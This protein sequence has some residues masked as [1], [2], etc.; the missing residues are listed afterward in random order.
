MT[1]LLRRPTESDWE[2]WRD[3]RLRMLA[4]TPHAFAESLATARDHTEEVWRARCRRM[5]DPGSFTVVAV[6]QPTGRWVGTMGAFTDPVRGVF[7]VSVYVDP[8]HRGG[9]LADRLLAEV[10]R[11]ARTRPG[12]TGLSLHVH[13]DNHRAQAFYRRRGF[14]DTGLRT[15]YG[16]DPTRQELQMR[17]TFG[18]PGP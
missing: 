16:L 11:W 12:A 6:E 2:R 7:L 15:P 10:S 4:D 17:V 1:V 8:A 9:G 14:V 5:E 3:L 13:E 18:E